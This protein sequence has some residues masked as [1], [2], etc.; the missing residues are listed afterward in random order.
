MGGL[1]Y[2]NGPRLILACVTSRRPVTHKR[3]LSR[4]CLC[5]S[6]PIRASAGSVSFLLSVGGRPVDPRDL[7]AHRAQVGAELASVVDR[8]LDRHRQKVDSGRF[9][10]TEQVDD[11]G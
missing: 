3:R 9:D 5:Y 7:A 2:V 4:T 10:H 6:E 1:P 11:V 8:M